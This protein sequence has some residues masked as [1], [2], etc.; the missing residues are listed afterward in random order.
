MTAVI[1]LFAMILTMMPGLTR[2][3]EAAENRGAFGLVIEQD[4][5]DTEKQDAI[6]DAPFGV[7]EKAFPLYIRSE[8][9]WAYGWD[10]DES[11]G[12]NR[13]K[14][15]DYTGKTG[16]SALN[17]TFSNVSNGNTKTYTYPSDN[18]YTA[19]AL[20]SVNVGNS[21]DE[22]VAMLG[23]DYD[24]SQLKLSLVDSGGAQKSSNVQIVRY[25]LGEDSWFDLD[26]YENGGFMSVAA[27]DFDGDGKDSIIVY[28][29]FNKNTSYPGGQ[30][31]EYD[32]TADGSL[33]TISETRDMIADIYTL[34][35][36]SDSDKKK[37]EGGSYGFGQCCQY[38]GHADGGYGYRPGRI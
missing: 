4:L 6:N 33:Y 18:N 23:Y 12:T 10:G 32:L 7:S 22:Y 37:A 26:A 3:A 16:S 27:G 24:S 13:I 14:V 25:G 5:T 19:V 38:S 36:F 11:D 9:F 17:K 31:K 15:S 21:R 29:L 28:S 2:P 35:G 30:L 8:L 34:L 1:L 20:D